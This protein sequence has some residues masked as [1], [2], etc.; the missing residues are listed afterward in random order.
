MIVNLDSLKK[1]AEDKVDGAE[2][3]LERLPE[4]PLSLNRRLAEEI[5]ELGGWLLCIIEA[6]DDK[7]SEETKE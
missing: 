3:L 5:I 4:D 7:R 6:M 2:S 1:L